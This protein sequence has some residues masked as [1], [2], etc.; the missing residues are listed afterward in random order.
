MNPTINR[1][2]IL[3]SILGGYVDTLSFL[4][5]QGLF[6]AHVTG[7][8]VTLGA[9]LVLG[10]SGITAKLLA[11][12]VFCLVI[13][14]T[15]LL[16]HG[17][18]RRGRAP[19]PMMLCL[20]LVLFLAAAVLAFRFSPFLGGDQWPAL[21]TGMVLVSAMAIQNGAQRI[22]LPQIPPST[23]MTGS[24]TQAMLDI[25]DLVA[26][27]AGDE[28]AVIRGRFVRLGTSI[29][30]FA[31]GCAAAALLVHFAGA[32]SYALPPL[33]ALAILL[34]QPHKTA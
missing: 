18:E 26:G 13:I 33:L 2:A 14:V 21:I 31:F 8:F 4:S 1:V 27:K 9:A 34:H 6:A 7:N 3:L 28:T 32:A 15:R 20:M 23:L 24:T 19:L 10:N 30:S 16:A 25:A 17:L 29:L 11:L 5:L 12:P 22:H